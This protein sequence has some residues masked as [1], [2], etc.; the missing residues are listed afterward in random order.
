MY[1][2]QLEDLEKKEHEVA[3]TTQMKIALEKQ[4]ELHHKQHQMQI[5]ELRNDISEKEKLIGTHTQ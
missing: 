2:V 5:S 4:M 1:M 3:S